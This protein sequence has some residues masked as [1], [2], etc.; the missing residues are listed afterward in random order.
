MTVNTCDN[1]NFDSVLVVDRETG[2]C[3]GD[4]VAGSDDYSGCIGN[5]SELQFNA[6]VNNT[7]AIQRGSWIAPIRC[8]GTPAIDE[9]PGSLPPLSDDRDNATER[10]ESD[11]L[12][13]STAPHSQK[14]LEMA[15]KWSANLLPW[16]ATR[17]PRVFSAGS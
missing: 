1:A 14:V 11:D 3:S 4:L 2:P 8:S 16:R 7:H 10:S 6:V 5:T 17:P 9:N 13:G 15:L 12:K